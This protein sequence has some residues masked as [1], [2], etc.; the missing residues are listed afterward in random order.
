M[1]RAWL[2]MANTS[3]NW[4][5]KKEDKLNVVTMQTFSD[6]SLCT[7]S[8]KNYL[9]YGF[10]IFWDAQ[11][12]AEKAEFRYMRM[13]GASPLV[14]EDLPPPLFSQEQ[15]LLFFGLSSVPVKK[16]FP[17]RV[18]IV[19]IYRHALR[20]K[21]LAFHPLSKTFVSVFAPCL[22][23]MRTINFNLYRPAVWNCSA[24]NVLG[25]DVDMFDL[26]TEW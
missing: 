15:H 4:C 8:R 2:C 21:W 3:Y 26:W 11:K 6:K 23:F 10:P 9:I 17:C 25:F 5:Q 24:S 19:M 12:Y 20:H 1:V 16:S 14:D 18:L 13:L 22:S 7:V